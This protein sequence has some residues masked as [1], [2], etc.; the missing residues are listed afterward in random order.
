MVSG[1]ME[2][3]ELR[4]Q[5]KEELT[6]LE[7]EISNILNEPNI[8]SEQ[9]RCLIADIDRCYILL[10]KFEEL[11]KDFSYYFTLRKGL[12]RSLTPLTIALEAFEAGA[13]DLPSLKSATE[14]SNAKKSIEKTIEKLEETTIDA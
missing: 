11:C 3:T 13:I 8:S 12:C 6:T 2:V 1:K 10:D 9:I 14:K 7:K 5:I 4:K